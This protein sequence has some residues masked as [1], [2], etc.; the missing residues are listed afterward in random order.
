MI[1]HDI[2]DRQNAWDLGL[3]FGVPPLD[4]VRCVLGIGPHR[5]RGRLPLAH[6]G[7]GQHVAPLGRLDEETRRV[8]CRGVLEHRVGAARA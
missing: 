7:R 6:G 2:D 8:E 4:E 5:H 1:V 3:E